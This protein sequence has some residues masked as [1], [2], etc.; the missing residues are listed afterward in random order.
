MTREEFMAK[1]RRGLNGLSPESQAEAVADYNAHFDEALAAGRSEE[2]A[3]AALG[4]PERLARELKTE[5]GL[6]RWEANKSPSNAAGA[7]AGLIGLGAL[8]LIIL[9]PLLMSVLSVIF[10][11]YMALI[12]VFFGGGVLMVAGPFI[13]DLTNPRL[14]VIAGI[15]MVSGAT[16]AGAILTLISVGLINAIVWYGRLHFRLL[17]PAIE[18]QG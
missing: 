10:S 8:D 12:A 4:D 1:L 9:L 5:S 6:K 7:I 15:G 11:L 3:A 2:E 18:A 17:K 16:F 13:S 14:A